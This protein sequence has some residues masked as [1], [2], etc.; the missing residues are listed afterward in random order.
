MLGLY[1]HRTKR[2]QTTGPSGLR[3][4]VL[5]VAGVVVA[6]LVQCWAQGAGPGLDAEGG[7]CLG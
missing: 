5:P 1:M 7:G 4:R 2:V 3:S 6:S